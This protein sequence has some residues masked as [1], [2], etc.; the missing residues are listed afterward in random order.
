MSVIVLGKWVKMASVHDEEW[1]AGEIVKNPESFVTQ[2]KQQRLPAHV[3]TFMQKPP[4]TEPKHRAHFDW[5]NSRSFTSKAL[6][7]GGKNSP[8]N[9]E[10]TLG[11]QS[12]AGWRLKPWSLTMP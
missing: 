7:T 5:D 9:P 1:T 11:G 2:L 12:S 3:F 10:K 4:D 6:T 8:R